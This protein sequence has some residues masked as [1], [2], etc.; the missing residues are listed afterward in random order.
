MKKLLILIISTLFSVSYTQ[1][2]PLSLNLDAETEELVDA[3]QGAGV[4]ILNAELDCHWRKRA[5]YEDHNDIL[6]I[7]D[8]VVLSTTNLL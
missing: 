1:A 8:G 2:Q 3:L 4:T 5:T 7:G 6:G